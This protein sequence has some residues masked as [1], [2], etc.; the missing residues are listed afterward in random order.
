[1]T[2]L[3]WKALLRH[4]LRHPWQLSLAILGIALGV[5]VVVAV[6]LAN[7][8]ARRSFDLAMER[9]SGAAT[10]RIVGGSE[11]VPETLY[12]QLRVEQG[13]RPAAPVITGYLPNADR[14]GQLLQILGVDPFAEGSFR[15]AAA[16][17]TNGNFDL[18]ALLLNADAALLP[19]SLGAQV[20][21]KRGEQRFP[22]Q[23]VGTLRGPELDG[24]V[25]VDLATA[26]HLL[27]LPGRLSHIDL[28]L[29]DSSVSEGRAAILRSELPPDLQLEQP[30]ERNQ[31]MANLSA[32]F[33]LNLTAMS[34]LALVV[35]MF[36]IYNA[37]S[38]SVVQR[39][40][41]LG[42]LRALGVSRRELLI[43]ILGEALL[44]GLAGTL[45]GE[46]LGLWLGSG[47]VNLVTRTIND[48]YYVLSIRAFF[49]DPGS[50]AKGA[51]LGVLATLA[52][53][54]LPACEAADAP[55]GA[56]LSR[57]YLESRWRASLP[58]FL[59]V[60]LALLGA[61][62]LVLLFSHSLV[63]GFIG[64]FLLILGCA[65]LT[66]P[67][68]VSL[69][70]LSQPLTT[71]LGLLAR[72]A[73]RD[74]VRHLS[75]TGIAVAALMV[76]FS[77]TVGVGVM[78][79]SFR[80]GVAIWIN[81]LL[82]ADLYIAPPGIEDSRGRSEAVTAEALAVLRSEP[83]VVAVS[84]YRGNR[85][86]LDGRPVILIA[87]DLASASQAGYRL[88]N[89]DADSAWRA[90]Q[91]GEAVLI[92]EP[93]AYRRQITVG[94]ALEL[95]T[96]QG[97]HTFP[98]AGVF[99]D[100]GSE[101]GRILLHRS[102][103]ARYWC[104]PTIGS[105]AVFAAPGEN[106]A[107]LRE[108]LQNRL[109][110]TQPLIFRSN[111]DIQRRTLDIFD[112]TFTITNVLRLLAILVAMVGVLSALM[113]LQ[114]ERVREFAVLR[115]TGMTAGEIGGLVSLQT[116]FMGA[117][118]GL[119]AIP[120]GLLLAAV[121]IFVINRRAFGWSLPFEANPL[122][123]L[124]TLALAICAALLAG[125]YPIWRMTRARPAEALRTE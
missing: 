64:L 71:R 26:Q 38:F 91:T 104:D 25:I 14:P 80:E 90:F 89:G 4:P 115:T 100:Y 21:L 103:Y 108:R 85:V 122:L 59:L 33:S 19:E 63:T 29:P 119:L 12:V 86:D 60:G 109:S 62:G 106:L 98:I 116:G 97:P 66:P 3:F 102:G 56:V 69:V 5:A 41:L 113:A 40:A 118:A 49:V 17:L 45:L 95:P 77:A 22:L 18:G 67:L 110:A 1:M 111:R 52:A 124:E 99:L 23:S 120:T 58:R 27:G 30:D 10:H 36:L 114:L 48:L 54:W 39:R 117:A 15:E 121:L 123:L 75:R 78:V 76:A 9:I 24:L 20:T 31:A 93:L 7:A 101:H 87:A 107:V 28:I 51:T 50:L 81:D 88:V 68:V 74:V 32:S 37:I 112:R 82:N 8:S 94:D 83:G 46:L 61:G 13:L 2:P 6:D 35:G 84:T 65:L 43:G 44:L 125:L 47:L 96:D 70:R 57:A 79:D 92:S 105:V 72:M 42:M 34:L 11:G 55:P 53:A 73:N 16:D